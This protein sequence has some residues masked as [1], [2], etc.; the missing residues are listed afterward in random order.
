MKT[1]RDYLNNV[2]DEMYA[3]IISYMLLQ[4]MQ[5]PFDPKVY[6]KYVEQ[7]LKVLKL[8][9]DDYINEDGTLK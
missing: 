7:F 5:V 6:S 3:T 2:D 1:I 4:A 9:S 8:P